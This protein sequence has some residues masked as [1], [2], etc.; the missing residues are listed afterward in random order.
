ML[1]PQQE[2]QMCF[3]NSFENR[4]QKQTD[5]H[6]KELTS[7][8]GIQHTGLLVFISMSEIIYCNMYLIHIWRTY[9]KNMK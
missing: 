9:G 2:I 7:F 1:G 4:K 8:P 5:L 6:Q 3:S